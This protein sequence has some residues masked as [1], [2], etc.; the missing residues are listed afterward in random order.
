MY[1]FRRFLFSAACVGAGLAMLYLASCSPED[2]FPDDPQV[3]MKD[4]ATTFTLKYTRLSDNAVDY[5]NCYDPDGS[6][7]EAPTLL[8]QLKLTANKEY[9]LELEV[10][11]DTDPLR[12]VNLTDTISKRPGAFRVCMSSPLNLTP[13]PTDSDGKYPIGLKYRIKTGNA[14]TST[15]K[16]SLRN[17]TGVKDGSCDIGTLMLEVNFPLRVN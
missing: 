8:T 15:L 6:G 2:L 5:A 12:S 17:Q 13:V 14:A 3:K 7:P 16:V 4:T 10:R 9:D 1:M 11:D